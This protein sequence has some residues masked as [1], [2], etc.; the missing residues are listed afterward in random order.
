MSMEDDEE[1]FVDI[2]DDGAWGSISVPKFTTWN[3]RQ[4]YNYETHVSSYDDFDKLDKALTAA[5]RA[6]FIITDKINE[7][8]RKAAE[9]KLKYN[10][11]YQREYLSSTEK[12]SEGRRFRAAIKCEGLENRWLQYEQLK[13]EL[14]RSSFTMKSELN[15]LQT[16]AHNLRQQLKL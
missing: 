4:L 12:T 7:Y 15:T 9:A 3:Q 6:L 5:R 14:T 10:R 2:A 13:E 8:D 1:D 11:Q 16:I